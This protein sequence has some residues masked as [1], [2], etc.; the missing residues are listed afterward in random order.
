MILWK[1]L[2]RE[3][4]NFANEER[5]R[6]KL[7]SSSKIGSKQLDEFASSEGEE[8]VPDEPPSEEIKSGGTRTDT[9]IIF[10]ILPSS[11]PASSQA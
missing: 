4:E 10:Q 2:A 9:E 1:M 6:Q 5:A 7:D 3:P 11:A 8:K